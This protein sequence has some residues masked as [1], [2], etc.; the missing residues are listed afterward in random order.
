METFAQLFEERRGVLDNG[1]YVRSRASEVF[2]GTGLVLSEGMPSAPPS[3]GAV[4]GIAFYSLPDLVILDDVVERSRNSSRTRKMPV[5]IFDILTC[6]SIREVET[7]FSGLVVFAKLNASHRRC[8]RN[9][10]FS[11][12]TDCE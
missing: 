1:A 6:K 9:Q 12:R 7:L 11:L 3:D 5:E 10:A 4:F 8:L 2:S